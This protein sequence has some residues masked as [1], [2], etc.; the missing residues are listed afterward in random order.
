MVGTVYLCPTQ[1]SWGSWNNLKIWGSQVRPWMLL[2]GPVSGFCQPDHFH[3]PLRRS[4][5]SHNMEAIKGETPKRENSVEN[6]LPCLTWSLIS[7]GVTSGEFC[8]SRQP[9]R[10]TPH[11][12]LCSMAEETDPLL[13]G[14]WQFLREYVGLELFLWPFLENTICHIGPP[15]P[16]YHD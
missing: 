16:Q 1:V 12:T 3:V 14:Q 5:V 10:S 11:L 6:K 8:S 13:V 7:L 2:L 15:L 9:S 4:G